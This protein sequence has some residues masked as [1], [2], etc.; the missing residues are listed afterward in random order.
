MVLIIDIGHKDN[1]SGAVGNGLKE[2][3]LNNAVATA[4]GR[5]LARH[6]IEIIFST[7]SLPKR[8]EL[9]KKTNPAMFVSIHTNS[10]NNASAKGSEVWVHNK[11][12]I[13]EKAGCYILEE[14][15]SARINTS[16]GIK[17][18]NDNAL[19][20]LKNTA[21]AA[22]LVEMAFI[23]NAADIACLRDKEGQE[24]MA[25]AIAKGLL[26]TFDIAY[27]ED[28]VKEVLYRVCLGSYKNIENARSVVN[29]AVNNG[30]D[31]AFVHICEGR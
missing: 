29:K 14:I 27:L 5:I 20:V 22:I 25:V 23:S 21:G 9:E 11:G 24:K 7:G 10:A 28:E 4:L 15:V 3:D 19:Y 26:K 30:F 2:V 17:D 16:R 18:K 13:E 8:V 31:N 12:G 6:G 1:D